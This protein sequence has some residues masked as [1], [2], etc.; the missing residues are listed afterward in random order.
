MQ[1]TKKRTTELKIFSLFSLTIEMRK[2]SKQTLH[3][4]IRIKFNFFIYIKSTSD[5][6]HNVMCESTESVLM[7]Q[8]NY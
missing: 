6:Y 2:F 7:F 4:L 5:V 1:C 3:D 8:T